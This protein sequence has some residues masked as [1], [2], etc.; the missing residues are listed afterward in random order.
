MGRLRSGLDRRVAIKLLHA[1]NGGS[2]GR[3]RLLREAQA[4]A[5]LS[6]P[7]VVTVYDVGPHEDGIYVA[8]ELVDGTSLRSWLA[9]APREEALDVFLQAGR[10]LAAAHAAGLVH[11][12]FKPENVLVDRSGRAKVGDFGLARAEGAG[13]IDGEASAEDR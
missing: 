2:I 11:R 8:M 10:G 12:D 6:H 4:M 7:H 3:A 1:D 13:A 5:K 9:T